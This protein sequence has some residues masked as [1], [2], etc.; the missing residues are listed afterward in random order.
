MP[1][2]SPLFLALAATLAIGAAALAQDA[3]AVVVDPAIATMSND[4]LVE[5]RQAAMKQDGM[6]L[7][8]AANLAGDEAVAAATILLQNFTNLPDLFKEG[9]ATDKSKAQPAVWE[10]W[11]DF[12]GRFDADAAAAARML[13]AAK[14]G[15]TAVYTAAVDE[16]GQSCGACH[17][18]YRGH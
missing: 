17:Q 14:S 5:A 7:R 18:T 10:N 16:L 9:S 12:K 11:D 4:Q 2:K 3:P 13:A 15:D 1:T 8:G 6:A